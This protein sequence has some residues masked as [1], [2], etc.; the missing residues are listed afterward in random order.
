MIYD[1][2]DFLDDCV[3]PLVART[4]HCD[5][6]NMMGFANLW[7]DQDAQ[8]R[9]WIIDPQYQPIAVTT[10]ICS[11]CARNRWLQSSVLAFEQAGKFSW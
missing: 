4:V 6:R 1:A 8:A 7:Q 10:A 2:G 3:F 5:S 11:F 9:E